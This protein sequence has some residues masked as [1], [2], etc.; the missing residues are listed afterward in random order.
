MSKSKCKVKVVER[1]GV[2]I[3]SKLQKSYPFEQKKCSSKDCFVCESSGKGNCKRDNITY[4]I[5]CEKEGCQHIYIGESSRNA[6]MRGREH[7]SGLM[8]EK[9]SSALYRHVKDHHNG[10]MTG[11]LS[12]NFKM[13]VKTSHQTALTRQITEGVKILQMPR[14]LM[15]TKSGYRANDLLRLRASLTEL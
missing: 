7:L 9:D 11:T 3:K 12:D 13:S 2:N 1:A 5:T 10:V 8:N 15:N 6:Y 14:P 4:E